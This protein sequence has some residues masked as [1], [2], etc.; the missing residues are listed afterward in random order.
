MEILEKTQ[1]IRELIIDNITVNGN[2]VPE[3]PAKLA[4]LME[5]MRDTDRTE[6]TKIRISTD[7]KN[8]EDDRAL[9]LALV[10]I[11][12]QRK[13]INPFL[14]NTNPDSV[15]IDHRSI[16]NVNALPNSTPVDGNME[17]GV[18]TETYDD[19]NVRTEGSE[20]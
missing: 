16:V 9:A 6:L 7:N 5:V 2:T 20:A 19:F 10:D 11:S 8:S 14:V 1:R 18:S 13:G 12:N 4:I 3:D 15:T 17:I